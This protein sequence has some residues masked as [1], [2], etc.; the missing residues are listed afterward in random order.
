MALAAR[1]QHD[2]IMRPSIP[3]AAT[4][5]APLAETV[6]PPESASNDQT[7]QASGVPQEISPEDAALAAAARK[8]DPETGE[9][10]E[11]EPAGGDK[12]TKP[13]KKADE[14]TP[15]DQQTEGDEEDGLAIEE[16]APAW[17]KK[18]VADIRKRARDRVAAI[19]AATQ[20][21]VGDAKWNEAWEAANSNVSQKYREE[22]AKAQ[23][24]GRRVTKEKEALAAKLAELEANPPQPKEAPAADPRPTRE[25]FDDPDLFAEALV[26]WGKRETTRE[27]EASAAAE[28]A[29]KAETDRVAK[30]AADQAAAEK[31]EAEVAEENA[32][33][34]LEWQARVAA[35]EE[36]Y[37]DYN[38][39]VM[40]APADGGPTVTEVMAA[41][42][43]KTDN[44]PDVAYWLA[45]HPDESV[46]IAGLQNQILQ[47]GEIMKL[48]GRLSAPASRPRIP[49]P[50]KPIDGNRN[51][52]TQTNPDDEDMDAYFARR[53][54]SMQKERR[55][56]FPN[57][58]G[59]H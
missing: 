37:G 17:A 8:G 14:A 25:G 55:P 48:S 12:P 46:R 11:Q 20:A 59:V 47:Y 16:T 23:A 9:I 39:I 52:P 18:Q 58:G 5:D 45:M 27:F 36:R 30:E 32:K 44:G 56:F 33:I 19:R 50:I 22:V 13:T 28:A 53:S 29:V 49:K 51:E 3:L 38:E 2:I 26:A 21:E 42:L 34:A 43:T 31:A 4:S 24:E 40:R 1:P 7:D 6:R 15:T 10:Q 41:A 57:G 35:A 54:P